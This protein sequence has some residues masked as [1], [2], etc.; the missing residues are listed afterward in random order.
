[1]HEIHITLQVS[2][3]PYCIRSMPHQPHLT[4][5]CNTVYISE[6][7]LGPQEPFRIIQTIKR[8]NAKVLAVTK[9]S[10]FEEYFSGF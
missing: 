8:E 7:T 10:T 6:S 4:G 3:L 2:R 9:I 5:L 1:M